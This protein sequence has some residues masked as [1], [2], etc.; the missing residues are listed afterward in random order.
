MKYLY[1]ILCFCCCV[2]LFSSCNGYLDESPSKSENIEISTVEQLAALLNKN[3]HDAGST[4][5]NQA[6]IY[7]SDCYGMTTDV[8]D[9]LSKMSTPIVEAQMSTWQMDKLSNVNENVSEWA[10]EYAH[11]YTANLVLANI[12]NV[13]GNDAE[14]EEVKARAYTMR[15]YCY[16]DLLNYYCMPYSQSTLT[17]LGLPLKS[18]P[19]YEESL[20]RASLA[21]TYAFVESDI[22]NALKLT[23]PITTNGKL[24][25]WVE[26]GATANAIAARFYLNKG[27]YANAQK[28]AET[29]LSFSN[30]VLNLAAGDV[31]MD[32][33]MFTGLAKPSTM[34]NTGS[35]TSYIADTDG[36]YYNRIYFYLFD[37]MWPVPSDYFLSLFNKDYD[38]RYK[39]F[40]MPSFQ[41][42]FF[43]GMYAA[44]F[45][46]D[47]PGYSVYDSQLDCAPNAAE[48]ILIKA[49]C[50]ARQGQ[51]SDAMAT[52]DAFRATRFDK[53]A[54]ASIV[55]LTASDKDTAIKY[56][57]EERAREFPYTQR[58]N[59]IRRCNFN[60][61]PNDNITVTKSF[62]TV[63]AYN[64]DPALKTY[65]LSPS[66]KS[67]YAAAIPNAEIAAGNGE[68]EQNQ[69]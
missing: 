21:D 55:N 37:M 13:S 60:D 7:C 40:I 33:D 64:T 14:R 47:V 41:N 1:N 44:F 8:Y 68:I 28:Y 11:I 45:T 16:L 52:L 54:P 39:F 59:D 46:K 19:N 34:I 50:Q 53:S 42:I 48:M 10:I 23:R 30:K 20:K 49:E 63:N 51:I 2:F 36:A 24:E 69:Y 22:Q 35:Y 67:S 25:S 66:E 61:D 6:Q 31:T 58:W 29:A 43:F 65:T 9:Q 17:S 27:D 15:A 62:Y 38:L 56:I 5:G 12:D 26:S 4:D 3:A 57:L 18:K 32:V